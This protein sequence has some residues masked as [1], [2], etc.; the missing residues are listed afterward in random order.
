MSNKL[1]FNEIKDII[2]KLNLKYEEYSSIYG[3]NFFNKEKFEERYL[4]ALKKG[5]NLEIFTHAEVAFFNDLKDKLEMRKEEKRIRAEKPF[6]KKV[7]KYIEELERRWQKY[8]KTFIEAE[9]SDEA[10]F[11]CGAIQEFYNN[12]WI[13]FISIINKTSSKDIQEYNNLTII[14]EKFFVNKSNNFSY[15][16]EG[17]L[18]N[19]NKFGIEK[20]NMLF[21][22]EGAFLIKKIKKFTKNFNKMIIEDKLDLNKILKEDLFKKTEEYIDQII[23]DFR[24]KN[25]I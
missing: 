10:S 24:F 20:A 25:L 4:D 2:N 19:M 6:T 16:I 13:K 8:P 23:Y 5:M 18:I 21:L 14:I 11:F 17:Y 15:E 7:E 12:Y 1:S 22:K 9:I 3:E